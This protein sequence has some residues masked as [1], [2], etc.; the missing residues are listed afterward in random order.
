MQMPL[1]AAPAAENPT[2]LLTETG[3]I[4]AASSLMA[5][6]LDET[7]LTEPGA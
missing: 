5:V 3:Y 4:P 2:N 1:S 6:L 7:L